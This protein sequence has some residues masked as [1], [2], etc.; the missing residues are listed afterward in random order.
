MLTKLIFHT[1]TLNSPV[2]CRSVQLSRIYEQMV[3]FFGMTEMESFISLLSSYFN[4]SDLPQFLSVCLSPYLFFFL[5]SFFLH[6]SLSWFL[7]ILLA[8]T[9]ARLWSLVLHRRFF[10][11][12]KPWVPSPSLLLLYLFHDLFCARNT[13]VL[14][15]RLILEDSELVTFIP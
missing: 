2:F 5:I 15:V 13:G 1:E 8:A 14:S 11:P 7:R 3:N 12:P 4:V 6:F 10:M 9:L